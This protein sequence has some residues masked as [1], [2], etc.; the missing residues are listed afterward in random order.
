[1][2]ELLKNFRQN[3]DS[4]WVLK[5]T[6]ALM[7]C[8]KGQTFTD[9]KKS[10]NYVYNLLKEEEMEAEMLSFPADGKTV[11]QDKCTPIGWDASIGKLTVLASSIPFADPVIAD[12]KAEPLNLVKHSC[13]AGG[14]VVTNIVSEA[15]VYAGEDARG[16]LV[17][18]E[19]GSRANFETISPLLDL[20]AIGFISDFLST[21]DKS[22]GCVC[23]NNAATDSLDWHANAETR[24]F[25]GFSISP[26][27]GEKLRKAVLS[28]GVLVKAECDGKRKIDVINAVTAL[29]KG[30]S[31]KE[32]W[33][34]AHLYEPFSSD[35]SYGVISAIETVRLINRMIKSGEI[36]ELQFSIRLVFAMELYGFAAVAEHFGG[37][38]SEKTIGGINMDAIPVG[39]T[40]SEYKA[41]VTP[42]SSPFFGNCILKIIAESYKNEID[43]KSFEKFLPSYSD[44]AGLGDPTVGLPTVW[45]LHNNNESNAFWHNSKRDFAFLD[46]EKIKDALALFSLWIGKCATLT[47]EEMPEIFKDAV[48]FAQG[49]IDSEAKKDS[50]KERTE[51]FFEGEKK[52]IADFKRVF[53]TLKIDEALKSLK[54]PETEEKSTSLKWLSYAEKI[55]VKRCGRGFPHALMNFPKEKRKM[56]PDSCIYGAF[57]EILAYMDGK[58]NL[59][60]IILKSMWEFGTPVTESNVKKYVNAV[61]YLVEGGYLELVKS[62]MLTKE[63]IKNALTRLGIRKGDCLL[64]HGA[65]VGCGHV[66]GGAD[67]VIDAFYDAVGEDGGV[68]MPSFTRPYAAF[69]GT[70]NKGRNFRPFEKTN[71]ENIWTGELPKAMARRKDAK[72]SAH[73]S[74]S[75]S[76]IGKKAEICTSEQALSDAPASDTSPMAKALSLGGKVCFYGCRASSNTF[77]HYIEYK[78]KSAF[79][80]NAIVKIKDDDGKIHTEVIHNHVPGCRDFYNPKNLDSKFYVRAIEKGLTI[81]EEKLGMGQIYV[82][83]LK[84]LYEIG[85]EL[86][87]EDKNVT[88][89]DNENCRFCKKYR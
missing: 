64:V 34:M 78:A 45:P 65:Q 75:W 46:E 23:W 28:G 56:L 74:H 57:A 41:F 47:K 21:S 70:L 77:I 62:E 29:V 22:P 39:L 31:E 52:H 88:L 67:A 33:V 69:E 72:R 84:E 85:M 86:F 48:C 9:Y 83:D 14:E 17:L 8:E 36:P 55:V 6:K 11:Y 49:K 30:K 87:R 3:A 76:G 42:Y 20:G 38:L 44:D 40:D 7:E 25:I 1:M 15:M 13:L 2:T 71:I 27:M 18:L 5:H 26:K 37:D 59:K 80:E 43:S 89:C 32:I 54:M 66:D 82:M 79:L 19:K 4:E 58:T 60:E 16:A 73:C 63:D 12:F 81:K 51:L 50:N 68:L 61:F 53:D 24:D 35:N 10:A